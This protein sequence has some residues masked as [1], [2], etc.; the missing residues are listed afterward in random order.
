M[1]LQ[2]PD[3]SILAEPAVLAA[4][5]LLSGAA[6]V[7]RQAAGRARRAALQERHGGQTRNRRRVVLGEVVVAV[8]SDIRRDSPGPSHEQVAHLQTGAAA[9]SLEVMGGLQRAQTIGVALATVGAS[10]AT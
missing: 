6:E 5:A 1:E 4:D 10:C 9:A 3:A 8:E 7:Q 2:I